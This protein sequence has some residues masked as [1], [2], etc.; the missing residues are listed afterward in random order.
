[1]KILKYVETC[2]THK[3]YKAQLFFLN[4]MIYVGIIISL[5]KR[6]HQNQGNKGNC[7]RSCKWLSGRAEIQTL[8]TT[9]LKPDSKTQRSM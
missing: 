8:F 5:I 4:S 9:D 2:S 7:P 1:M 3:K 6:G